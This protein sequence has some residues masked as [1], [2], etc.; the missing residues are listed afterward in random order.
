LKR[1][2]P[3]SL[4]RED[5]RTRGYGVYRLKG[6]DD[7]R[8]GLSIG[9][10][11]VSEE[12]RRGAYHVGDGQRTTAEGT[13]PEMSSLGCPEKEKNQKKTLRGGKREERK[14]GRKGGKPY[15]GKVKPTRKRRTI[16]NVDP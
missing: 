16:T 14:G 9:G 13:Y 2:K 5:P 6:S 4:H 12:S 7:I 15:S 1:E 8:V 3:G 10:C 11:D